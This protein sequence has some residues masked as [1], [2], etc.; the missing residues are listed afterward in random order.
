MTFLADSP[1]LAVHKLAHATSV[2]WASTS[3]SGTGPRKESPSH[4]FS[5]S[6]GGSAVYLEHVLS[7]IDTIFHGIGHIY[8]CTE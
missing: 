4:L 1:G 7:G 8:S 2:A 5:A 3:S 6:P